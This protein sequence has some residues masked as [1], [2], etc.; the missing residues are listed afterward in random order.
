[1]EDRQLT[2]RLKQATD[3]IGIRMLDHVIIG[4]SGHYSFAD[5]GC[6]S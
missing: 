2:T 3:I 5:N 1:M 4:E 6:L